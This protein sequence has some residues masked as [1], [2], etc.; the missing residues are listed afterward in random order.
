MS[1]ERRF[2]VLCATVAC[3]LFT[4]LACGGIRGIQYFL[5]FDPSD[6]G[7]SKRITLPCGSEGPVFNVSVHGGDQMWRMTFSIRIEVLN[8]PAEPFTYDWRGGY[9]SLDGTAT[10]PLESALLD[11]RQTTEAMRIT[12][13][14]RHKIQFNTTVKS[15]SLE[16]ENCRLVEVYLGFVARPDESIVCNV[17]PIYIIP[18]GMARR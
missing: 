9:I 13:N 11:G 3:C 17:P 2:P 5:T 6:R 16:L 8:E 14:G 10:F 18:P 12:P 4:V 7:G 1:F 15:I